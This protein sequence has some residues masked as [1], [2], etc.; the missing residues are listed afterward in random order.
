M[1]RIFQRQKEKFRKNKFWKIF[2]L[3][4][5]FKTLIIK[6]NLKKK[7]TKINIKMLFCFFTFFWEE[8]SKMNFIHARL[9]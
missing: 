6:F 1:T 5:N 3:Y 7:Q 8:F 4:Y 9:I 2:F